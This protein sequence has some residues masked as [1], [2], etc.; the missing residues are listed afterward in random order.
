MSALIPMPDDGFAVQEKSGGT[1]IVGKL[2]KFTTDGKFVVDKTE[3]LRAETALVAMG[4]V[5][6]WT[7]WGEDGEKPEH[8]ITQPGQQHPDREELPDLDESKWPPGLNGEPSDPWRD[9][10]YLHLIDP[11]TGTDYTFV[12]ESY[13]GRRGIGDLKSQIAN[14]RSAHPAAVPIV[15]P[16]STPW[17]TKYGVK[18]RPEFKVV[19]W[20]GRQETAAPVAQVSEERQRKPLERRTTPAPMND[21][22]PW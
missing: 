7:R 22:I 13:G 1:A 19:G 5:T 8:R 11:Q 3:A 6:C 17:K 14:V 2:I 18:Q 9:T 21:E 16:C 20:R 10:R 4:V 15:K 12:T